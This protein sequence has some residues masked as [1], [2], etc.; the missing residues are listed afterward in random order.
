[1]ATQK[2]LKQQYA[3]TVLAKMADVRTQAESDPDLWFGGLPPVVTQTIGQLDYL[4]SEIRKIF[5]LPEP[6][7]AAQSPE[8][9]ALAESRASA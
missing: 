5:E 7:P 6:E 8:A 4:A 9:A 2:Q 1:M 3:Q